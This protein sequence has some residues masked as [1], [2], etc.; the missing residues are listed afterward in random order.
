M[1]HFYYVIEAIGD[2]ASAL[3]KINSTSSIVVTSRNFETE[4]DM[5]KS[6][7]NL[8]KHVL[9]DANYEKIITFSE[10]YYPDEKNIKKFPKGVTMVYDLL[11]KE[12]I[13]GAIYCCTELEKI[14]IRNQVLQ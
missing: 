9:N 2:I 5:Q 14:D 12:K 6:I 4:Q 7:Q 1:S 8:I 3:T 10:D 13:M 11:I